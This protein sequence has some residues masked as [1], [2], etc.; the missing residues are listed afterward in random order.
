MNIRYAMCEMIL[1]TGKTV[2]RTAKENGI[3]P[4]NLYKHLGEKNPTVKTL[5]KICK[6]TGYKICLVPEDKDNAVIEIE[7]RDLSK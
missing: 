2:Y 5:A 1:S 6:A 7:E 4:H 3:E